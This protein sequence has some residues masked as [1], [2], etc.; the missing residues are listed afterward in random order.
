MGW[1]GGW[2]HG[3]GGATS[4]ACR[5]RK[6]R[7]LC[8]LSSHAYTVHGAR[9]C[10]PPQRAQVG[11]NLAGLGRHG[12]PDGRQLAPHNLVKRAEQS[13]RAG[14]KD[15]TFS[16]GAFGWVCLQATVQGAAG[17]KACGSCGWVG[18]HPQMPLRPA[19]LPAPARQQTP[20]PPL[21]CSTVR[22]LASSRLYLRSSLTHASISSLIDS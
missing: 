20:T 5:A 16:G 13:L 10:P 1:G 15:T 4:P 11:H 9:S 17:R 22:S 2:G 18:A 14:C 7:T 12:V 6:P 3:H 19:G 8:V 21:T